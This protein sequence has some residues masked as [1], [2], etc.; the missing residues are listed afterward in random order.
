MTADGITIISIGVG[1]KVLTDQDLIDELA[2]IAS[3]D[4]LL[5]YIDDYDALD[6]IYSFMKSELCIH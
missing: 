5:Y 4:D 2:M 3:S 1:S 6:E